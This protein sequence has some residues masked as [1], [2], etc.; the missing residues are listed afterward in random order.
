MRIFGA[1]N[2]RDLAGIPTQDG[3]CVVPRRLF[4]SA[5]LAD[6]TDDDKNHLSGLP[7][8]HV[9]DLRDVSEARHSP[10][11]LWEGAFY[12]C[13][14]A[15]PKEI[16]GANPFRIF[17]R[18]K[19]ASEAFDFMCNLYRALPFDN[20]AYRRLVALMQTDE[21]RGVV[22]HCSL[23]KDRTGVATAIVLLLLG[24]SPETIIL[25]YLAT[26]N[27]IMELRERLSLEWAQNC[28]P[29][30]QDVLTSL[31]SAKRPFIEA[32]FDSI[33][34]KYRDFHEYIFREYAIDDAA[35]DAIRS[36]YLT[37]DLNEWRQPAAH[38]T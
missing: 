33:L 11:A 15:T 30:Q 19:N 10:D 26:E 5:Q 34:S 16:F 9:L 31:F 1:V 25:D 27:E 3:R 21:A 38:K 29:A 35:L 12:E 4:R 8:T 22:Y 32:M 6:L 17:S 13:I 23:G 28:T 24:V 2:F 20:A 14:P 36:R 7:I 18:V 37:R